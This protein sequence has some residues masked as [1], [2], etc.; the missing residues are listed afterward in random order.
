MEVVYKASGGPVLLS[1]HLFHV[2][3]H[4]ATPISNMQRVNG[5]SGEGY[6]FALGEGGHEVE[7]K[8]ILVGGGPLAPLGGIMMC[9]GKLLVKKINNVTHYRVIMGAEFCP[10]CG[11]IKPV[12]SLCGEDPCPHHGLCEHACM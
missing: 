5:F 7:G 4:A 1:D 3:G 6:H 10:K 2:D 12:R 11:D 8:S 9:T